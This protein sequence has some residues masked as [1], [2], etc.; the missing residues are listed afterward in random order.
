MTERRRAI[1]GAAAACALAWACGSGNAASYGGAAM[2]AAG[3][4]VQTAIY[5]KVS[6]Y[7]CWAQCRQGEYCD[8]D[9]GACLHV[10]CGGCRA[11]Q[12]CEKQGSMEVCIEPTHVEAPVEPPRCPVPDASIL[13]R[14]PCDAGAD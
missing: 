3:G 2:M 4:V 6:G 13:V 8:A 11:D 5:R 14:G 10:P 12:R 7:P 1:A 9:A